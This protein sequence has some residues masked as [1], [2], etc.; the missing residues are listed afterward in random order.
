MTKELAFTLF[1][2]IFIEELFNVNSFIW[3]LRGACFRQV[4]IVVEVPLV[5]TILLVLIIIIDICFLITAVE[6]LLG[7]FRFELFVGLCFLHRHLRL[8]F[9]ILVLFRLWLL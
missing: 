3:K 1:I 2:I 6:R 4:K 7:D 8:S 9:L 5:Y